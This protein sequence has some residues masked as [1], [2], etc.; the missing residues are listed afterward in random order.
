M[1]FKIRILLIQV[2]SFNLSDFLNAGVTAHKLSHKKRIHSLNRRKV[3]PYAPD[4]LDTT[5]YDE[6]LTT[7]CSVPSISKTITVSSPTTVAAGETFD[8]QLAKYQHTDT[9]C[10]LESEKGNAYAV[11]LLEEGAT[12]KNCFLG[13]SQESVHCKGS[14]TVENCHWLELCDDGI[15]FHMDSGEAT[16]TGCSFSNAGNKALQFNGGG[17]VNV[18]DV[19]FYNVDIAYRSCGS[20]CRSSAKR[21]VI[22]NNVELKGVTTLAGFNHADGDT[23]DIRSYSGQPAKAMCQ[24]KAASTSGDSVPPGCT[25]GGSSSSNDSTMPSNSSS[26]VPSNSSSTVPSTSDDSS[27]SSDKESKDKSKTDKSKSSTDKSDTSTDLTDPSTENSTTSTE[28]TGSSSESDEATE[29]TKSKSKRSKPTKKRSK[30]S[31]SPSIHT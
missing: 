13:Y 2:L 10:D 12:L 30:D 7:E 21:A 22:F 27:T 25:I 29:E 15:M 6:S 5:H 24:D 18:D 3:L 16:V 20:G 8:C 1:T 19:C 28:E 9:S 17:T 4:G 14:C 26:T 23:V 31:K 11:F